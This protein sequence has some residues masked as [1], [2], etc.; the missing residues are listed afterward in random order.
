MKFSPTDPKE[1]RKFFTLFYTVGA[2]GMALTFTQPLFKMLI[3]YSLL[4]NFGYLAFFHKGALQLKDWIVFLFVFTAGLFV[5]IIGVN[6]G[7]I[8]GT[9]HYGN[10][11][12]IKF[13]GTPILIGLN[14]LFLTY[15][16]S[17]MLQK[18]NLHIALK[19]VL[20]A[21]A[22][23]AYDIVLEQVAH[24]LDMWY[25]HNQV[26]PIQNYAAW[27]ALALVFQ[28]ILAWGKVKTDNPLSITI[29]SC[30]FAF[31]VVLIFILP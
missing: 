18:T 19:V 21:M 16:T 6:T 30:Q 28:T 10:S 1:V 9:Y 12:G 25:W 17:S 22:M 29:L 11:L 2:L 14:W 26:V 23:L 13:Y 20:S 31:F 24:K 27:L 8:F 15:S 4:L 3:P 7:I 5:E